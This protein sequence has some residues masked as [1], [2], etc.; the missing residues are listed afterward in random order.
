MYPHYFLYGYR[1]DEVGLK[2]P[3]PPDSTCYALHKNF[4]SYDSNYRPPMAACQIEPIPAIPPRPDVTNP[5]SALTGVAKRMAY[6]PPPYDKVMRKKF[7]KFVKKWVRDN[8]EPIDTSDKLDFEE[9]LQSTNYPDW[10]KEEIRR[11]APTIPYAHG[12]V[13]FKDDSLYD[14]NY[15]TKEEYYPEYKHHRGIWARSDAAKAVMGPFFRKIEKQL[16]KLP[17]F[18]KKVPK[19]ERPQYINDFMNNN[20]LQFQ[21]TDYTSFES[22]FTTDMM[23]DCEFELYR[24]MSSKNPLAQQRC[25]LIFKILASQNFA[26][27]KYFTLRVDA[28]RM[29]G[30]MNTSL[31]N[32]FSNLMFLLFACHYYKRTYSGPIIEGDDALIG[33]NAR[34][35][36]E[37]YTKM[38]LNVKMEFVDDISEGSFC[39]LVYDPTEL[40]NIREPL[41]TLCTTPWVTRKYASS[42]STTYYSLLRSKAL[43]LIYEY[44][45]C[46][47]I[48]DY[49]HKLF[50]LTSKYEIAL[51]YEDSYQYERIM[52]AYTAYRENKLPKGNPGP[53]TRS[54]MEKIF[55][56][57]VSAQLQIEKEISTMTLDN[58]SLPTVLYY[59]PDLWKQNFQN[60]SQKSIYQDFRSVSYPNFLKYP[61]LVVDRIIEVSKSRL[62]QKGMLTEKEFNSCK[63]N[64]DHSNYVNYVA[65]YK[66]AQRRLSKNSLPLEQR[67]QE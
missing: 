58:M 57:P 53:R 39:G 8:L 51:K 38:G 46:P 30:E 14:I 5:H 2:I 45:G 43:S 1:S 15:F 65:R 47:I 31:G 16:F 32:G 6:S 18:I 27:N 12:E 37:Y 13:D 26:K 7:R 28:K 11:A 20:Y 56:I 17:Y 66:D 36:E 9:W 52:N 42:N 40:I 67:A 64:K 59:V 24:F 41:E 22:L 23:D 10:R 44:P 55:K 29:S 4:H 50:E 34:I 48:S 25:R 54:L 19:N 63:I 3:T 33:L 49:G 61:T 21:G 35:P 62:L 60:Y